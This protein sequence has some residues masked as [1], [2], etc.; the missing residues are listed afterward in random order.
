MVINRTSNFMNNPV[1]F[2]E[3]RN[4][5]SLTRNVFLS[6]RSDVSDWQKGDCMDSQTEPL[7]RSMSSLK[8]LELTLLFLLENSRFLKSSGLY[9][10][11]FSSL[12]LSTWKVIR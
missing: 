10:V 2:A 9:C 8:F 3:L 5:S 11:L 12:S 1:T 7:S 6:P 4:V